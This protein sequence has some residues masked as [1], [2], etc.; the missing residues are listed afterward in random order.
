V[1][2]LKVLSGNPMLAEAARDAVRRWRYQPAKLD[3]EPIE[4]RT[5]IDV[6]FK[7]P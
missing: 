6:D 4:V 7:L 5:D 1:R 2:D 3:G